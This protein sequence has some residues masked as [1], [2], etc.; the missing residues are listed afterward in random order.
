MSCLNWTLVP[1][2][3]ASLTL[4]A[5]ASQHR[6]QLWLWYDIWLLLLSLESV[7]QI[8]TLMFKQNLLFLF[9]PSLMC[10]LGTSAYLLPEWLDFGGILSPPDHCF[11]ARWPHCWV[12]ISLLQQINSAHST[13]KKHTQMQ[14]HT[15]IESI[16]SS[17]Y[18][19]SATFN[20][21]LW[22]PDFSFALQ[23]QR[24]C[25]ICVR[26]ETRWNKPAWRSSRTTQPSLNVTLLDKLEPNS[27]LSPCPANSFL[28]LCISFLFSSSVIKVNVFH[29]LH[30][31]ASEFY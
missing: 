25:T 6:T 3:C 7:S 13:G 17:F 20:L 19:I 23:R 15:K 4:A 22:S 2:E 29:L 11:M 1:R 24:L 12:D 18:W 10:A 5:A 21:N 31:T 9:L 16:V 27:L 30:L 28:N 8:L 14:F 26:P